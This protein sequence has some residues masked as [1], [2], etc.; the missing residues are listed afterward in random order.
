MQRNPTPDFVFRPVPRG[1]APRL[2]RTATEL[3]RPPDPQAARIAIKTQGRILFIDPARIVAVV[4]QGNYVLLQREAGSYCVRESISVMAAK[5]QPYGFV[6]IHRSALVNKFWLEEISPG[7]GGEYVLRLRGG[8]A[9]KITR[10]YR[11]N[12]RLLADVWVGRDA[13]R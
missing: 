5:L 12:L 6:R 7:L 9:F 1:A 11:K 3:H 10:T 8:R 2:I 13:G 4:A